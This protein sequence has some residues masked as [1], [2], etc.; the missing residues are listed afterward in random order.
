MFNNEKKLP[1]FATCNKRTHLQMKIKFLPFLVGGL[2]STSLFFSSCLENDVE[3]VIFPAETSITSFSLGTIHVERQGKD[4]LGK[5]T[6]FRDTMNCS[7]YPFIIDQLK[8]TIENRDSL[9]VGSDVS[10]VLSNIQADTERIIYAKKTSTGEIKDTLWS[11]T[12]SIDFTRPLTFKVFAANGTPGKSYS[13]TVNIHKQVPDTLLWSHF[14]ASNFASENLNKQQTVVLD[15]TLYTFGENKEGNA[16]VETMKLDNGKIASWKLAATLPAGTNTYSARSWNGNIYFTA[17]GKLYKLTLDAEN[18]FAQVGSLDNLQTL[19]G[20]GNIAASAEVMFAYNKDMKVVGLN[21]NGQLV[22]KQE[23]GF[24]ENHAFATNRLSCVNIPAKHNTSLTRN[25]VMS[26]NPGTL[27]NDSTSYVYN[28][29]T[30]D[31]QWGRYIMPNP[32]TCP[33]LEN[34]S[35]IFYDNKL[36]A[37]GGGV[38][39]KKIKPFNQFYCS[40]DNGLTWHPVKKCLVF[41]QEEPKAG[42][43]VRPFEN[44]YTA[45]VEGSYST[46]VDADNFIWLIWNNGNMTRGRINRL[47]FAPKW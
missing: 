39:T 45:D 5:D 18:A 11:A 33:N 41:P 44:Y 19:V 15:Q 16:V 38:E 4:T 29:T 1:T 46:I 20:P 40:A 13:V 9:P 10:K 36:Y 8:R 3:E 21:G 30:N 32:T 14:S 27:T 12:D 28:Y 47:G 43:N 25:I 35:M 6:I 23:F 22:S 2:L 24:I 34:I 37:F 31:T 26:N 7:R 17:E 42:S